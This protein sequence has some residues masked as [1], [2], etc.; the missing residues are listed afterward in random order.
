MCFLANN[1][2]GSMETLKL[3]VSNFA[4]VSKEKLRQMTTDYII[5]LPAQSDVGYA[6]EVDLLYP[7]HLHKVKTIYVKYDLLLLNILFVYSVMINFP[8]HPILA[9]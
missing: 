5:N 1:L 9:H 3:P 6:F 2:Y 8:W 7:N 4:W